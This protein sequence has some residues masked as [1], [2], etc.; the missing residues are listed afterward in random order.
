MIE[1]FECAIKVKPV[2]D[3]VQ[4]E[5][6][7]VCHPCLIKPLAE[8]YLG[9]LK[10]DKADPK[11]E[12]AITSLEKAWESADVLTIAR[13]LDKIKSEVGNNLRKELVALDCFTQSYE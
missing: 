4:E 5:D 12:E 13:E 6:E 3:W 10:E 2:L 8:Y 9:T 1:G 11:A 7:R